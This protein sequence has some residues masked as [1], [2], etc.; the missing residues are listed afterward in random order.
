[1]MWRLPPI[2]HESH[3]FESHPGYT[4]RSVRDMEARGPGAVVLF[5]SGE[6]GPPDRGWRIED[7]PE[8]PRVFPLRL[9]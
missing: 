9:R 7:A 6:T 3:E 8:G 1:M 5:G 4:G 2:K